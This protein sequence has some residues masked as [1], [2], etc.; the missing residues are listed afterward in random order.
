MTIL[1]LRT[2]SFVLLFQCS[3]MVHNHALAEPLEE[4]FKLN[5][6]L[7]NPDVF[8]PGIGTTRFWTSIYYALGDHPWGNQPTKE[9]LGNLCVG[10]KPF[11][12]DSILTQIFDVRKICR[13]ILKSVE[14]DSYLGGVSNQCS[15]AWNDI[16][17]DQFHSVTPQRRKRKKRSDRWWNRPWSDANDGTT[18]T[19]GNTTPSPPSSFLSGDRTW[20]GG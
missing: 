20:F 14:E 18:P 6:T 5:D 10:F 16:K 2:L 12:K 4:I 13:E 17:P 11:L 9:A 8:L 19:P 7:A 3:F 1:Q 15:A